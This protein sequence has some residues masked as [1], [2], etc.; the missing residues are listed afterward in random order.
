MRIARG[1]LFVCLVSIVVNVTLMAQ[2]QID[3]NSIPKSG[4]IL[5]Y[6]HLDDDLIWMLPFW[7]ITEKFIGGAMPTTPSYNTIIQQQQVF[8]NNNGYN[9]DYE[10]NWFTPWDPITDREYTQYYWNDNP[11]YSYLVL[12][13]LETRL[14]NNPEEMSRYE[15]NKMK[16]KLEQFIASTNMSRVITHN[17]WGEYG[18]KHHKALN[19]AVRELA[20]KYRKDVW[21][22]GCDNGNFYDVEVPS[23]ITYT[24]GSF[25]DPDLYVGIRTIYINNS[26]WTWYT[27]RIPSGNHKF[28]KIV[29]GGSDKSNILTGES[30]TTPGPYQNEP[31]AYIFDG[32]DDYMTLKGNNYPAFTVAMRIRPDRIRDMDIAKMTEYPLSDKY[33]RNFFLN[34]D[35]RITAR[36]YDGSSRTLT[37][38]TTIT[39]DKWAH[40]AITSNGSNLKLYVN[41]ALQNTITTGTAITN[42]VTPEL[43]LGQATLTGSFFSGQINDVRMYNRVL[44]DSEIADISGMLYTITSSAGSGGNI[45]PSGATTVNVGSDLT[46]TISPNSGYQITDVKV[47]NNSVGPVSTYTFNFITSNHTIDATFA[48]I[49]YTITSTYGTG[50]RIDP[51]GTINVIQGQNRTFNIAPNTGFRISDVKVDDIS[52]GPVTSYTFS[53]VT[54]NHTIHATFEPITFIITASAGTGGS[55]NPSG[56]FIANY[57]ANQSFSITANLGFRISDVKVDD[58][59]I[60][61][62]TNYTFNNITA[63]HSIVVTFILIPTYT[64]ISN[65]GPGGTIDP[66]G[67]VTVNQGTSQTYSITANTGYR[68]SDVQVD[69]ISVGKPSSYTFNNINANHTIS[70]AYEVIPTYTIVVSAG[71]GGSVTPGGTL[72]IYEGSNQTF[73]INAN[74][75]YK[76]TDVLV[77]G[78]SIGAVTTYTFNNVITDHT[79][80]A[81]F[82]IK[83]YT[84]TAS[85]GTGGSIDPTGT[86]IA[87]HGTSKSFTITPATGYKIA[88][89][90][91]DNTPVGTPSSYIFNNITADHT[92]SV[93]FTVLTYIITASSGTGGNIS[94]QGEV[95]VNYGTNRTFNITPNTG[96]NI[97]DVK[98]DNLSMGAINT[99]TFNNIIANHT[100]TVSFV[101]ITYIISASAGANGTISPQGNVT[102]NHGSSRAFSITSNFGFQV[103]DVRVDNVSA[104]AVTSYTFNNITGNHSITAS[105]STATYTITS[106]AGTGGSISP[107]GL[108]TLIHGAS[109]TYTIMAETGYRISD[110]KVDGISVGTVNSYT[111]NNVTANHTITVTFENIT[112]TINASSGAGGTINPNGNVIV[113]Y[114]SSRTFT[115]TPN[116]GYYTTDVRVDNYSIGV[117]SSY[118]FNNVLENHSISATFTPITFTITSSAGPGGT[119]SPSGAVTVNHGSNRTFTITP[120][121]GYRISDVRVDNISI[122]TNTTYAFSNITAD[123]SISVTFEIMTYSITSSAGSGGTISPQGIVYSNY[124]ASS[125]YS[126]TPNTGYQISD[127]RVDNYSVGPVS[128][129]SFNN[130]TD[131]HTISASFSIITYSIVSDAG[132]GGSI[133]PSGIISVNYGTARSFAI[134]PFTGY[135]VDDVIVDGISLGPVL[136]YTFNNVLENHSISAVFTPITYSIISGS[137]QGGSINPSGT[138]TVNYGTNRTFS[139][140]PNEGYR[141]LE[142]RADNISLGAVSNYTF[143]NITS[144]HTISATFTPITFNITSNADANG[145]INPLGGTTRNYGSNQVYTITP[146]IGYEIKDV[147]VDGISIGTVSVYTFNNIK[148]NHTI[149][150]EFSVKKYTL[151]SSSNAG[152]T[153]IPSGE[154]T[155][156]HGNSQTYNLSPDKGYRISDIRINNVSA[157]PDSAF[158]LNN[159][160]DNYTI[161]A[162]FSLMNKYTVTASTGIGGSITPSGTITLY[163]DSN[164]NYSIVPEIGYRISNVS[165]DNQS[166][167]AVSDY[168]FVNLKSNHIISASFTYDIEVEVYPNPFREEFKLKILS[169]NGYAF[170]LVITDL[171]QKTLH[172][173]KNIPLNAEIPVTLNVPSGFY[174]IRLYSK[175]AIIATIKVIKY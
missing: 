134:T 66:A 79:I 62:V 117:V 53:N 1:S 45:N 113:N 171:T 5:I 154:I 118:T 125:T 172:Y 61:Q 142:V 25:D 19:K 15:I 32:S 121:Q 21:M 75:G 50:G 146:N 107:S 17:N 81:L 51:S 152:G 93:T 72:I 13:H 80:S 135:K 28:I 7:K 36:I 150:A 143:N 102:V 127:V 153:I 105:F 30:I 168:S 46:Y 132:L 76:I 104:G 169:P 94:P 100:I 157:V 114:G 126:I 160:S 109:R 111:F 139:I 162:I 64:I 130:I 57:G 68:I 24:M 122:G 71:Y 16:A 97:S 55:I 148:S 40:I 86:I 20:V 145:S 108:I 96:Y 106:T 123:H 88:E 58:I 85:A 136:A 155:V 2:T 173:H 10:S 37:S 73:A 44:S 59:S 77:D 67:E 31:G 92:I 120:D 99:Y 70:A 39:A 110:V 41:G 119:I 115:I 141:I 52:L 56:T 33:D 175:G 4:T 60:G 23:G 22:L 174:I 103:A 149:K 95:T 87:D 133:S 6:S 165:V 42:Y 158:T 129:Y 12:D 69:N 38:N 82:E 124:G 161:E 166:I 131:N 49:T 3:F 78:S 144:D 63:N 26:R 84:I 47:D 8:L 163:E 54:T 170:D 164:Q 83:T 43:V 151:T 101:P 90:R 116:T 91:I 98:I 138:I 29:S 35:G 167:G 34:S 137:G 65:A 48:P 18:H 156:E 27:D 74:A 11:D 9:I 112:F 14:Y 140:T 159:I 89:V 128:S 147:K